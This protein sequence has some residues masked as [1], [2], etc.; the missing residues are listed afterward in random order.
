MARIESNTPLKNIRRTADKGAALQTKIR[1]ALTLLGISGLLTMS[2]LNDNI[3]MEYIA[4]SGFIISC[5]AIIK[6]M[7]TN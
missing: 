5:I 2:Y 7:E 3:F 6:L 1:V 4:I